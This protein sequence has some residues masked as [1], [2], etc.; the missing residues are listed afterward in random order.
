MHMKQ[1]SP[2]R[3]RQVRQMLGLSQDKMAKLIGYENRAS[4]SLFESGHRPITPRISLLVELL[5]DKHERTIP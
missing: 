3:F 2:E 5:A 4:V 1:M